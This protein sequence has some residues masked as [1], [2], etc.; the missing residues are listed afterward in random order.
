M[1]QKYYDPS[2]I[3]LIPRNSTPR[4]LQFAFRHI[5]KHI[6]YLPTGHVPLKW[7]LYGGGDYPDF[8]L[9][10]RL[11]ILVQLRPVA[12]RINSMRNQILMSVLIRKFGN[13]PYA[14]RIPVRFIDL[15]N[16]YLFPVENH[17]FC[18]PMCAAFGW[19]AAELPQQIRH[20]WLYFLFLVWARR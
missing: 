2:V 14:Y 18:N 19:T 11:E 5:G 6:P 9:P 17:S 15:R 16:R 10:E 12:A 13:R 20:V 8:S 3:P 7:L 4:L 1:F